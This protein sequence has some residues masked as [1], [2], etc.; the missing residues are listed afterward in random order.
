MKR[1]AAREKIRKELSEFD[2][3]MLRD[4]GH[5]PLDIAYGWRGTSHTSH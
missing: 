2:A 3:H 5:E 1:A 4:T